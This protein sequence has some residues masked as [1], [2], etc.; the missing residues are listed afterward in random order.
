MKLRNRWYFSYS[1]AMAAVLVAFLLRLALVPV[2]GTGTLYITLFPAMMIVAVTL[3][4]G[5]GVVSTVLGIILLEVLIVDSD[6]QLASLP[7]LAVR[8]IILLLTS[9]Y[10][11]W[12]SERLRSMRRRADNEATAARR[13]E[14]ALR[15]ANDTLHIGIKERTSELERAKAAAETERQRFNDVL[16]KM[17]AYVI[18]LSPEYHVPFANRF[19]EERF[20]KSNG[21]RCYEYLFNRTEPCETCE[22]YSVLKTN[23]IHHWEWTGPDGRNYDIYDF[24]F[25]DVDGSPLI[26]EVGLDITEQ[27]KAQEELKRH[28]DGLESLVKE[29]T[30]DLRESEER[31]QRAQEISHLGSWELDLTKNELTWSDEVYRIFG[32]EPR[33]FGATYDAFLEH[34]HPEDRIAVGTAYSASLKENRDMY[35]MEHRVVRKN[36][37]E[38]RIVHEKCEHFRDGSSK[39]IRSVGMV[40]DI[41]ERKR[42]EGELRES[43]ERL[44]SL[45]HSM[46]EGL[47][48][49]ELV[50]DNGV[51]VDY[52]IVDV[53]PAFERITGL[54]R[55]QAVG[56]KASELYGTGNPPYLDVYA[57]VASGAPP[58]HFETY[59]AP[60]EKHF[61]ISVFSPGKG[62]FATVFSDITQRKKSE[63]ELKR[64]NENL[65][66]FAYAASHDLQEPLRILSSFSQLLEK[67]YKSKLD[68]D[69]DEFISYIVDAAAR[70]QNLIT[71]LLAYS[72][73]GH[74]RTEMT[75]VDCTRIVR[76]VA[77]SMDAAIKDA[78]GSVIIDKLP[79]VTAHE[80]GLFQLFQNLVANAIKFRSEEPPK[81]H[82]SANKSNNE[83]IFAVGDNGIGIEPQYSER[84][85]MIFQR[86]HPRDKYSGTGI[87]LSICKRIVE[88]LGGR[89]WV[90]SEPGKGST[91]YFT[92]PVGAMKTSRGAGN[93]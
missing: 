34:V 39:I 92:I 59:F 50:Y 26:M 71:D 67:R 40:H 12:V 52:V 28:R 85:F 20:G 51:A 42:A 89:I 84:I 55:E 21:H 58:E 30:K 75:Q 36:T 38:I 82:V 93:D 63:D 53:N 91:F 29:R 2:I 9:L 69:G 76:R 25:T 17:P 41:T 66:Q 7:S 77:E 46:T 35:E 90:E 6:W 43:E 57:R 61:S 62:N 48:N 56:K 65:E 45:Y 1:I 87:G 83:W 4:A 64:L 31:L 5:P 47:V 10:V 33:E 79:V 23:Q 16:D 15:K 22:T 49:H 13:A 44:R 70:M 37:G 74:K 81:I 68:A 80:T 27:K 14:E 54:E 18:L 60:M 3:G 19:F 72:R 78:G 32:L 73:A 86:L 11:G 8:S 24:P 88:N